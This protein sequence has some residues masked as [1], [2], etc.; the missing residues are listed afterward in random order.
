VLGLK[1]WAT[2]TLLPAHTLNHWAFSS[3]SLIVV[4][5]YSL[6]SLFL[7]EYYFDFLFGGLVFPP[8]LLLFETASFYVVQ[9]SLESY[10]PN[11]GHLP[12]YPTLPQVS[13]KVFLIT[14]I[15]CDM[16]NE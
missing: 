10:Y 6:F 3:P 4:L 2:T 11:Y 1:A 13:L 16:L 5:N 8:S 12:P 14:F 15:L 9:A 7:L